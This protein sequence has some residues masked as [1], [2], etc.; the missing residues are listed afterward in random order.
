MLSILKAAGSEQAL[1]HTMIDLCEILD[2]QKNDCEYFSS[3][4]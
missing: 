3:G 1:N 4:M 2:C